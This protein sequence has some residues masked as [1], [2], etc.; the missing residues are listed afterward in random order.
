MIMTIIKLPIDYLNFSFFSMF[1]QG[2]GTHCESSVLATT[3]TYSMK[4]TVCSDYAQY[5]KFH[6]ILVQ[7]T[8]N[9]HLDNVRTAA[10]IC[11]L[12][13]WTSLSCDSAKDFLSWHENKHSSF[14]SQT[15]ISFPRFC[16]SFSY[17]PLCM[18]ITSTQ[19]S[20]SSACL[21]IIWYCNNSLENHK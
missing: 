21:T 4:C 12:S 10:D 9:L 1:I 16:L 7:H 8:K 13:S 18:L 3:C 19:L 15:C 14:S 20:N 2:F 11:T 5:E 6:R 17:S